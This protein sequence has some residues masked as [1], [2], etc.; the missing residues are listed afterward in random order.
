M[1]S[2][3]VTMIIV[4]TPTIVIITPAIAEIM[5]SIAPPI[6]EKME[7]MIVMICEVFM[8]LGREECVSAVSH[9]SCLVI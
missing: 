8:C 2:T 9:L 3:I 5:A 4:I 6:A 1:T 7:P